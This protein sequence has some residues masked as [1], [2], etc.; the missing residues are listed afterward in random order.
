MINVPRD[1]EFVIFC[2]KQEITMPLD[3]RHDRISPTNL[4]AFAHNRTQFLVHRKIA[5]R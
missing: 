2:Q 5:L 3:Y 4:D 1:S